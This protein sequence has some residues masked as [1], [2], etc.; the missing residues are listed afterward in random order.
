MNHSFPVTLFSDLG[1][2][3]PALD[4]TNLTLSF[5]SHSIF[6]RYFVDFFFVSRKQ[7][8]FENIHNVLVKE[9]TKKKHLTFCI[10][11]I[12]FK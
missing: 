1:L 12:A 8:F 9:I 11:L 5:T 10:N 4:T 6:S 3:N 2:P 7:H